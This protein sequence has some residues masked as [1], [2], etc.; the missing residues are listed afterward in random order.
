[1]QSV[2]YARQEGDISRAV[3]G[4]CGHHARGAE[5]YIPYLIT[6]QVALIAERKI[7]N[8]SKSSF[9]H[10]RAVVKVGAGYITEKTTRDVTDRVSL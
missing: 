1:M 5:R 6:G 10:C 3:F 7:P 9:N 4:G 8:I 2:F